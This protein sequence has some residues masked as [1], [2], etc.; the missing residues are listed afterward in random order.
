RLLERRGAAVHARLGRDD[1][2]PEPSG[3]ERAG[4]AGF[5]DA[6][7]F[8]DDGD[9]I[10]GTSAAKA[11]DVRDGAV[12]HALR[13]SRRSTSRY[14]R[15]ARR[16]LEQALVGR[17]LR[18][19]GGPENAAT[20]AEPAGAEGGLSHQHAREPQRHRAAPVRREHDGPGHAGDAL[21]EVAPPRHWHPA[22]P[23]GDAVA[24]SRLEGLHDPAAPRT[25]R[26]LGEPDAGPGEAGL[27]D[28]PG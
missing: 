13:A 26:R 14:S 7:L 1:P 9:V 12:G 10:A 2:V 6:I 11:G 3:A 22:T 23:N 27:A 25:G 15:A 5:R 17:E 18:I 16:P 8:H 4:V 28:H 21:L 24:A 20:V 19:A